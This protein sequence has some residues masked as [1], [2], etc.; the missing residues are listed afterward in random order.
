MFFIE[1]TARPGRRW[2][3]SSTPSRP[4]SVYDMPRKAAITMPEGYG[5]STNPGS[6]VMSF[7]KTSSTE[8]RGGMMAVGTAADIEKIKAF[9]ETIDVPAR[10]IMIEVQLIELEANKLTDLG[11][12]SAQFGGGHT[13]GS[14]G[15]P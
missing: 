9:V 2:T 8:A 5:G 3:P 6:L 10:R 11:I 4:W 7:D 12:D 13:L 14:V 1:K 15:L